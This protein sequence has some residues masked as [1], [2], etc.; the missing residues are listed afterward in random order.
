M[1]QTDPPAKVASNDLLGPNA[2]AFARARV[3]L[4]G[5]A[6]HMGTVNRALDALEGLPGA[7][8]LGG[9]T[10]KGFTTWAQ[11]LEDEVALLRANLDSMP[12]IE[13]F[14]GMHTGLDAAAMLLHRVGLLRAAKA[15]TAR[16]F[17]QMNNSN[18]QRMWQGHAD[19]LNAL[20]DL[21]DGRTL[22]HNV[23]SQTPPV[24]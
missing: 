16:A 3:S 24:R 11:G 13:E 22:G 20:L 15:C 19:D 12:S 6:E 14:R 7:A 10:S 1:E 4:L 18:S 2:L 21:L 9:W 8:L 5:A 23:N 17:D